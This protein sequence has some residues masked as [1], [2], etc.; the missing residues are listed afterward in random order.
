MRSIDVCNVTTSGPDPEEGFKLANDPPLY[1]DINTTAGYAGT[2]TLCIA[3]NDTD[4][5]LQEEEALELMQWNEIL[6]QWES[7]ITWVDTENNLI[8][9]E[10]TH[11]S[12]FG[13][14]KPYIL[15]DVDHD[16]TVDINEL[17]NFSKAYGASPSSPN[18]DETCDI[19]GNE[20]INE[21]DLLILE[22][23]Y[24]RTV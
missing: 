11:L 20:I 12:T 14:L 18:W 10:T 5:T 1:Y 19:D 6:T 15:G 8:C 21:V 4:L 2:I 22:D 7:I 13:I 3:Y 17:Y 24:G 16:L 9:G 23:N